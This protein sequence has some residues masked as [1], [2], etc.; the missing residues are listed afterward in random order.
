V[1]TARRVDREG[2]LYARPRG[3]SYAWAL[4][5]VAVLV[6]AIDEVFGLG[7]P[8]ALYQSWIHDGIITGAA[9]LVLARAWYEPTTRTAWLAFG[10]AMLVWS[11]GSISWSI[12][13]GGRAVVPYPTFADIL[14][15]LWYPLMVVGI[16]A[17]IRVRFPRF[18]LH[19]W[20]DGLAVVLLVLVIGFALIIQPTVDQATQGTLATIVDFSYPILDVLLIGSIL[21]VYGLLGWRPDAMWLLIG[22][23][24]LATT[25]A[26]AA[27]AVQE[28]RGVGTGESYAFVWS[29]GALL[30]AFAAWVRVRGAGEREEVTGMRAVALPLLAQ[31][32][33]AGI[34]IY[35]LFEPVGKSER[36]VTL[37]VLAIASIQIILTRP[38][39]PVHRDV[40]ASTTPEG[41]GP[42][43]ETDGGGPAVHAVPDGPDAGV[44]SPA[45]LLD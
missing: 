30:L 36:L 35:A 44:P 26:D 29:L 14:W 19:R 23:G 45:A 25:G 31:A 13:Y 34:Q 24:I 10:L 27:F 42:P 6:E 40:P 11:A 12:V 2:E 43:E 17:L 33:A 32:L 15:L 1:R 4:L 37:A 28:A 5:S 39:A 22:M 38:R 8:P 41:P 20:M 16:A 9:V 3:L 18:E 21:G 7:G